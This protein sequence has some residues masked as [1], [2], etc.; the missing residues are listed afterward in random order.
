[1]A[2][3]DV[4]KLID[5]AK[6]SVAQRNELRKRFQARKRDLEA[7][8]KTIDEALGQLGSTVK[9]KTTKHK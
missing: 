5:Y 9:R 4:L 2:Y 6:L 3:R 7:A 8:I 1:M